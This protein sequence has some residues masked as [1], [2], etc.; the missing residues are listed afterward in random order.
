MPGKGGKG[1]K[2]ATTDVKPSF[3]E[4][5]LKKFLLVYESY[6]FE[7]NVKCSPDVINNIKQCI[8]ENLP[9]TKVS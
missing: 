6:S 5:I 4:L 9:L 1:D 7:H 8:E 3:N 2:K